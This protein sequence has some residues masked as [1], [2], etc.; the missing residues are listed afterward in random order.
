MPGGECILVMVRFP[1]KEGVREQ[2]NFHVGRQGY[3]LLA[4]VPR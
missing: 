4:V 1:I 2:K 3:N